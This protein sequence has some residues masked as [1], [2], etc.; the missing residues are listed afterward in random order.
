[1]SVTG[2]YMAR[3]VH[4]S[5]FTYV[6]AYGQSVLEY[7][8]PAFANL[9]ERAAVIAAS[10]FERLGEQPTEEGCDGDMSVAA[11]AAQDKGQAFYDTLVAIRQTSLNLFAA[12]L[13][14]LLEQQLTDLCLDGAFDKLPP[15]DTNL[16]VIAKWY[17]RNFNLDLY[18]LPTWPKIEQLRDLANSVK[19]G[20]GKSVAK[21]RVNRPDLFQDPNLLELLPNFPRMHTAQVV[22]LP[23]AGADIFV[24][25]QI[26]AEFSQ[27]ANSFVAEIAEYFVAHQREH[28]LVGG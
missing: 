22:R 4:H 24:T 20:E 7:V 11:E 14:H 12:G 13:F 5:A 3:R 19:H 17:H 23:M 2:L 10:E 25:T 27:A 15:T 26:F 6:K 21:L 16:C 18:K 8:I 9:S 28:Y 1:M